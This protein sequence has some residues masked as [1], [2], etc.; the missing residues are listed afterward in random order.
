MPK[1]SIIVEHINPAEDTVRSVVII[2]RTLHHQQE[3][4]DSP[5]FFYVVA[6]IVFLVLALR[7]IGL[8]LDRKRRENMEAT[9]TVPEQA[10]PEE[11]GALIYPGNE[12]RFPAEEIDRVPTKHLPYY[13]KL[14]D[15][16]KERFRFRLQKFMQSKI[17]VIY[18]KIGFK[19][20]P[21]LLSATAIKLSFGLKN[22]LLPFYRSIHIFPEEF[23]G[24][25]PSIRVLGRQCFRKP[26]SCFVEAFPGGNQRSGRRIKP[27]IT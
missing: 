22:Y 27:W 18:D 2:P 9:Y 1:D 4:D 25:E 5:A 7:L 10:L 8:R 11:P 13:V 24:I 15:T 16:E 21:I 3:S 17:F 20:M 23:W 12:L 6:F 26:H 14:P 19:E